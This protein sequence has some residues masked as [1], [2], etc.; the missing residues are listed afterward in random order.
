VGK[1]L[2]EA[3]GET[4]PVGQNGKSEEAENKCAYLFDCSMFQ[5]IKPSCAENTSIPRRRLV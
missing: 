1:D 2:V 5:L 4:E 3:D